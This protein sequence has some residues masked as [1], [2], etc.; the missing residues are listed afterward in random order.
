MIKLVYVVRRLPNLSLE[1]C[2]SYWRETHAQLVRQQAATIG[3]I[4]YLQVYRIDDPLNQTLRTSRGTLEPFDGIAELCWR[5]QEALFTSFASPEATRAGDDL[6]EDERRFIDS[7]RSAL[8]LGEDNVVIEGASGKIVAEIE[9][10]V[11][12]L[13]YSFR[14]LPNLSLEE[15]LSYWRGTHAALV[16]QQAAALGM[17]RYVQ[18]HTLDDPLN[19]AFRASRDALEPFDGIAE[20]W[21]KDRQE[22]DKAFATAEA[23][24]AWEEILE[25]E[26]RFIDFSRSSLWLAKEHLIFDE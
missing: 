1:E 2:H 7:P 22:L 5:D 25:D 16:R 13:V 15:C 9:S 26:R 8:C 14:R 18:V 20:L 12:K 21:W 19:E 10:P 6:L 4:R 17:L 3:L 23:Q 24:R 11:I